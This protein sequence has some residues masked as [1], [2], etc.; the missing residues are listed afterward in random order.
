MHAYEQTMTLTQGAFLCCLF[1]VGPAFGFVAVYRH[2]NSRIGGFWSFLFA[3]FSAYAGWFAS[4]IAAILVFP[5]YNTAAGPSESTALL[6][7][8]PGFLSGWIGLLVLGA[9]ADRRPNGGGEV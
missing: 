4:G 5:D 2:L 1:I 7:I 3:C 8:I 6:F 9:I